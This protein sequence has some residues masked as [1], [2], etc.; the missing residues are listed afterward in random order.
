MS[1]R[2]SLFAFAVNGQATQIEADPETTL[3]EILTAAILQ[4]ENER[5]GGESAWESRNPRGKLLD[6][7]TKLGDLVPNER[8][9]CAFIQL[10]PGWGA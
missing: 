4:T 2:S 5:W 7:S 10:K 9:I 8:G 1:A 3:S 6:G